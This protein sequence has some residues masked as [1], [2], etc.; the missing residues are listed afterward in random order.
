MLMVS[1]DLLATRIN[2]VENPTW[3]LSTAANSLT[4][5]DCPTALNSAHAL[6][7][8]CTTLTLTPSHPSNLNNQLKHLSTSHH[9]I[10]NPQTAPHIQPINYHS[11]FQSNL[12]VSPSSMYSS[13]V[14]TGGWGRCIYIYRLVLVRYWLC[15]LSE[16]KGGDC[17]SL[18]RLELLS[19]L[20]LGWNCRSVGDSL[21]LHLVSEYK[22][23]FRW[24]RGG[25]RRGGERVAS[26]W[27]LINVYG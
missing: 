9:N 10:T 26:R 8:V 6:I 19:I 15:V 12:F 24:E 1:S 2:K 4:V 16:C 5:T 7:H 3:Q 27:S 18:T 17:D 13:L 11:K 23:I 20:I 21:D 25:R 22:F 14:R